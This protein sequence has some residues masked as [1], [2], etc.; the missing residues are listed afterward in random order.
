M[1]DV[2]KRFITIDRTNYMD[3]LNNIRHIM[4]R[5]DELEATVAAREE[6]KQ[7]VG[8]WTGWRCN[9]KT[10]SRHQSSSD[11]HCIYCDTYRP[12]LEGE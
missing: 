10:R 6:E 7:R 12:R 4:R 1:D 3:V 2:S 8:E 5:L 11:V 9:C